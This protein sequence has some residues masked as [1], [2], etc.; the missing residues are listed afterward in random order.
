MP[1]M[2]KTVASKCHQVVAFCGYH[3]LSFHIQL[4]HCP[5]MLRS[6]PRPQNKHIPNVLLR[7]N[8][9]RSNKVL[10]KTQL[11]LSQLIDI[12]FYHFHYQS[13]EQWGPNLHYN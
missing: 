13:V 7:L 11:K 8:C 3:H 6:S 4:T 9:A 1:V 12:L 2:L 5:G 10:K